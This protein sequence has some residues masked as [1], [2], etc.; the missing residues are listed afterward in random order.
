MRLATLK[1]WSSLI[2]FIYL[3]SA[4]AGVWV[5]AHGGLPDEGNQHAGTPTHVTMNDTCDAGP[6]HEPCAGAHVNCHHGFVVLISPPQP[7]GMGLACYEVQ[8]LLKPSSPL[9]NRDSP[10][11]KPATL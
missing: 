7:Q 2:V 4:L 9:Q 10:P 3:F 1:T 6:G 11:P 8:A 5:H